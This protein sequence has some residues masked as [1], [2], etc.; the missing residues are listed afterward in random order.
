[1]WNRDLGPHA[2]QDLFYCL[3]LV[4]ADNTLAREASRGNTV[5][6]IRGAYHIGSH[7]ELYQAEGVNP[8]VFSYIVGDVTIELARMLDLAQPG[9]VLIGDFQ[10]LGDAGS[11]DSGSGLRSTPAFIRQANRDL[12]T[13]CGLQLS[14]RTIQGIECHLSE[15]L[16]SQGERTPRRFLITDK[17]GLTRHAYNLQATIELDDSPL[18]LGLEDEH[19]PGRAE[20]GDASPADDLSALLKKRSNKAITED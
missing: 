8:T 5:P 7:Y 20:G 6:V 11:A 9:Q 10:W 4:V 16:D 12:K 19:L 2:N 17:H 3:L 18:T 13:L 14:R 1:M 15:H